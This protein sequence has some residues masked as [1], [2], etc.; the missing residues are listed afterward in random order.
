MLVFYGTGLQRQNAVAPFQILDVGADVRDLTRYPV[1]SSDVL[2]WDTVM[3]YGEG[4]EVAIVTYGN[5]VATAK[6]AQTKLDIKTTVIDAPYLS[7]V[8]CIYE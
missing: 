4:T 7:S 2:D 3:T 8:P 5:G 1:D 6:I